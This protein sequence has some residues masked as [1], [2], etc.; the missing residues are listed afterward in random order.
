MAITTTHKWE[1]GQ[2]CLNGE[3][4]PI[5]CFGEDFAPWFKAKPIHNYLGAANITQTLARVDPRDKS[6]LKDLVELHGEPK[7]GVMSNITPPDHTDY[8][9][10]KAIYLNE[11]GLYTSIMGSTKPVAKPFQRWVTSEVL[12]SIRKTGR[13]S[14]AQRNEDI[15]ATAEQEPAEM[16][17]LQVRPIVDA[18]ISQALETAIPRVLAAALRQQAERHGVL[19]ITRS[20]HSEAE[21]HLLNIGTKVDDSNLNL[22]AIEGGPLHL[23][24]FLGEKGV[25]TD[26]LR[27]LNPTFSAEVKRRKL[28]QHTGEGPLWIAWSQGSWRPLYTEADRELISEV[29]EDPL[30][31]Q[32]IEMLRNT[33]QPPRVLPPVNSGQLKRRRG[34]YSRPVRGTTGEVTRETLDLFFAARRVDE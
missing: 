24:V 30:T 20:N 13:Y 14:L 22:I 19:E 8:N 12:P 10:G 15:S 16:L 17:A 29:F 1:N 7:R 28:A 18:A 2:L 32:N 27:R 31:K 4:A 25:Q 6:S 9:E 21:R 23:S 11:S 3:V 33:L 34:P 26:I 5:L